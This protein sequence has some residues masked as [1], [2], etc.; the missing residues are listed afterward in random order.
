MIESVDTA[1]DDKIRRYGFA[2]VSVLGDGSA[3][4]FSYTVGLTK[5]YLQPEIIVFGL[6]PSAAHGVIAAAV[7]IMEDNGAIPRMEPLQRVASGTGVI[8]VPIVNFGANEYMK[9]CRARY[10]D[11]YRAIQ[12]VWPDPSGLF[13]WED[14]FDERF[15]AAQI[16]LG[17]GTWGGG[18]GGASRT[19]S[20]GQLAA[21]GA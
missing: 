21:G 15:S 2:V 20:D 7:N 14:G 11:E 5:T 10:G 9:A 18:I 19:S 4:G 16:N 13:P 17:D 6:P 1:I 8:F 3:P 12:M